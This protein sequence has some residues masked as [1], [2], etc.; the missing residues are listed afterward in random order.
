MHR[1]TNI[2]FRI[3]EK[4]YGGIMVYFDNAATGGFKS[5]AAVSAATSVV[6]YLCANPGRSGH[7]LS[8][9]GAKIVES[10][11]ELFAENF[12]ASAFRVIFTKNCTEALNT[13]I[14]GTVKCGGHVVTTV[15]EHNSVLRPLNY[16]KSKGLISLSVVAPEKDK[17]VVSA[18]KERITDK[19]YLIVATM[20]S[21]VTGE[22]F[23]TEKI[24]ALA[25][26]KGLIF[27]ADGAQTGGHIGVNLKTQNISALCLAG[28]KA[29]GGIM[30]SG[31]LILSDDTEVSPLTFGGTGTDSFS[32]LQPEDYPEKLEAGTLNLPAIA[33]L[34]EGF[35][36]VSGNIVRTEKILCEKTGRM[37]DALSS[38]D[39][40]TCY[41]AANPLGIVSFSVKD[42][43]SVEIADILNS[44]YD[45]AVRGGLHCAPLTHKFLGTEKDGLTRVSL[46]VHNTANEEDFFISAMHDICER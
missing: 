39:K 14:L 24:G 26:E 40:I 21:N 28:H 1:Y 25:K 4:S 5:P 20:G 9:T 2:I 41:S 43:P 3:E 6:K 46:S 42:V 13:A 19:T 18:I 23:P 7:R 22:V 31:V 36:Y 8:V 34:L 16:L 44:E 11:R 38:I 10:A 12:G 30:G 45:V 32:V 35:R 15:Y 33:A 37:I 17:D 29:L 27:I